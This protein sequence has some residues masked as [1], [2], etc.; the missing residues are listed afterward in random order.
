MT[1]LFIKFE[2]S[3]NLHHWDLGIYINYKIINCL[4]EENLFM[5]EGK[6]RKEEKK[7]E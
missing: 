4:E 5:Q 6:S 3:E 2:D 1:T 7:E